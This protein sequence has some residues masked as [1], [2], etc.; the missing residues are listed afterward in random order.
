MKNKINKSINKN[1]TNLTIYNKLLNKIQS[2]SL[3]IIK[4]YIQFYHSQ[5]FVSANQN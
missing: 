4:E 2:L 1:I 5:F 3:S